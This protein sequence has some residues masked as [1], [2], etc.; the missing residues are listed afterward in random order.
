MFHFLELW[1]CQGKSKRKFSI[2]DNVFLQHW[3]SG[4]SGCGWKAETKSRHLSMGGLKFRGV[5]Y[6][7]SKQNIYIY[8]LYIH[9]QYIYMCI[10]IYIYINIYIYVYIYTHIFS[11]FNQIQSERGENTSTCSMHNPNSI[12]P[13]NYSNSNKAHKIY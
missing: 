8:I 2:L 5:P 3:V 4:N 13:G 9:I 7:T 12:F 10:Y 1:K 11:W 6:L